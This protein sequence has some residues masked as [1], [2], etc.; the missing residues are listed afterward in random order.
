MFL[1]LVFFLIC[2][3]WF[4]LAS[5]CVQF[6]LQ[7][8]LDFSPW[9]PKDAGANDISRK[10]FDVK[11]AAKQFSGFVREGENLLDA[12][13]VIFL[14]ILTFVCNLFLHGGTEVNLLHMHH[15]TSIVVCYK[16]LFLVHMHHL[17]SI[18]VC[19]TDSYPLLQQRSS[20]SLRDESVHSDA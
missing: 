17:T 3:F 11:R 1:L 13:L 5:F 9:L 19:Y 2:H 7:Y 4:L 16:K 14:S 12:N 20:H 8:L 6:V 18:F 15:L 10:A